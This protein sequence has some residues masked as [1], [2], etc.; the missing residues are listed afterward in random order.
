MTADKPRFGKDDFRDWDVGVVTCV[1]SYIDDPSGMTVR[2]GVPMV[3]FPVMVGAV[4][5]WGVKFWPYTDNEDGKIYVPFENI[6]D[7]RLE[8]RDS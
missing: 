5:D 6:Q 1:P 8:S 4:Y 2:P 7:W 3:D